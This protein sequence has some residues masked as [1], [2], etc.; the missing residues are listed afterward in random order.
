MADDNSLDDLIIVDE[1]GMV[2]ARQGDFLLKAAY[3]PLYVVAGGGLK[4][5]AVEG[6]IRAVRAEAASPSQP[7]PDL[8]DS[9]FA[10]LSLALQVRNFRDAYDESVGL[11]SSLNLD[12][13]EDE[14]AALEQMRHLAVELLRAD[15]DPARS[16]CM[17]RHGGE[18]GWLSD[19]LDAVRVAGMAPG[20]ENFG[21]RIAWA[22]DLAVGGCRFVR[23][24]PR[25]LKRVASAPAA[26]RLLAVLVGRLREGGVE[27]IASGIEDAAQLAALIDAGVRHFQGDLLARPALAGSIPGGDPIRLASL[28]PGAIDTPVVEMLPT[29]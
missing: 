16:I 11:V 14:S 22:D 2:F 4:R 5:W 18:I 3:Q 15:I 17:L 24:D 6:S 25:W 23:F 29:S 21:T 19:L 27:A 20:V 1:I 28:L 9:R 13:A 7:L 12:A 26:L 10:L 8:C